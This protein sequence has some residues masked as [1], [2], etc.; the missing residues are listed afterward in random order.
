MSQDHDRLIWGLRDAARGVECVMITCCGGAELQ[1]RADGAV[2]L[3]EL[4]PTKSDLYERARMLEAEYRAA[5][6]T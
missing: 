2:I 1:L 3:R 4:Y 5:G 6:L